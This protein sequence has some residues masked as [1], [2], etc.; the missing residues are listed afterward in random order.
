MNSFL[1]ILLY[2][3]CIISVRSQMMG[4]KTAGKTDFRYPVQIWSSAYSRKYGDADGVERD[5]IK[6]AEYICTGVIVDPQRVLTAAHCV[7]YYKLLNLQMYVVAGDTYKKE[8]SDNSLHEYRKQVPVFAIFIHEKYKANVK[9]SAYDIAMLVLYKNLYHPDKS[10]DFIN[11]ILLPKKDGASRKDGDICTT[12][13]WGQTKREKRW[14]GGKEK[15]ICSHDSEVLKYTEVKVLPDE[16]CSQHL[17]KFQPEVQI[18]V[19]TD[20]ATR[21]LKGDSGAPLVCKNDDGDYRL[22]GVAQSA[23]IIYGLNIVV[24]T[25]M[26]GIDWKKWN[27]FAKVEVKKKQIEY[28]RKKREKMNRKR[29]PT[30]ENYKREQRKENNSKHNENMKLTL[31]LMGIVGMMVAFV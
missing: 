8:T 4:G 10:T 5:M 7:H 27:A 18:C 12:M 14:V 19:G 24:Y 22:Y 30:E 11:N 31:I 13:G 20:E 2:V 28:N 9:N 15:I 23:E 1:F 16:A 29:I 17:E 6:G 26:R 21:L 25:R 3:T